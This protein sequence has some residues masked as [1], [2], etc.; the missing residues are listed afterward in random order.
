MI[1]KQILNGYGHIR[2]HSYLHRD[3][4]PQNIL[5]R[6]NTYKIGDFGFAVKFN[7]DDGCLKQNYNI[8]SPIYMSP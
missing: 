6:N 7:K 2:Q 5:I 1:F 3:L 8:G 4:K